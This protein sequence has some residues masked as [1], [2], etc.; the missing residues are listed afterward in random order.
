[1]TFRQK[2]SD[3][4]DVLS[5][6]SEPAKAGGS[7]DFDGVP[8][9]LENEYFLL[10]A[11]AILLWVSG[12][13]FVATNIRA[14][15]ILFQGVPEKGA[16]LT[17]LSI[18]A[19]VFC[20]LGLALAWVGRKMFFRQVSDKQFEAMLQWY[21]ILDDLPVPNKS[22]TKKDYAKYLRAAYTWERE[23]LEASRMQSIFN[24]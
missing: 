8:L 11:S 1:M 10:K 16:T 6:A 17:E 21:D 3:F 24:L 23:R 22:M 18:V 13:F 2:I 9:Y 15:I 12:F 20:A 14:C 4:F 7:K 5:W 19:L